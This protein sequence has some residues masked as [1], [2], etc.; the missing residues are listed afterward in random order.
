[1][2]LLDRL[3]RLD[4]VL[5]LVSEKSAQLHRVRLDEM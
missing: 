5:R 2:A 1:V 3:Q 4:D